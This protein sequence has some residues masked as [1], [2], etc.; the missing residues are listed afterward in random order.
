MIFNKEV[1]VLGEPLQEEAEVVM[2]QEEAQH[3]QTLR[4]LL[5]NFK[6]K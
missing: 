5:E 3:L 2:D 6:K 1:V 4:R